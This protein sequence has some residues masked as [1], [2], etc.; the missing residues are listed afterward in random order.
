MAALLAGF[1]AALFLLAAIGKSTGFGGFA[2]YL[3]QLG[4]PAPLRVTAS[5]AVIVVESLTAIAIAGGLLD[6]VARWIAVVMS[7]GFVA[8]QVRNVV[9]KSAGCSCYGAVDRDLNP[10]LALTRAALLLAGSIWLLALPSQG[11]A[12]VSEVLGAAIAATVL[13]VIAL[14]D[15]TKRVVR[16]D[17]E[18][19]ARQGAVLQEGHSS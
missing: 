5:V 13:A 4:L 18:S 11:P 2:D 15:Q 7:A 14:L 1:V 19:Q 10:W 3:G 8:L 12:W 17:R 6:P 9:S 16:F